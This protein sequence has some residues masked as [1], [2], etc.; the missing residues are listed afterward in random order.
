MI[1]VLTLP[2]TSV[3]M[4]FNLALVELSLGTLHEVEVVPTLSDIGVPKF[5]PSLA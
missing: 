2:A 3:E 1:L 4:S 5:V